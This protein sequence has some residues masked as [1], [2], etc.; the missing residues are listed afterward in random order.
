MKHR[1]IK[2]NY[3]TLEDLIRLT[4]VHGDLPLYCNTGTYTSN[5]FTQIAISAFDCA[6]EDLDTIT[7]S[8]EVARLWSTYIAPYRLNEFITYNEGDR[9]LDYSDDEEF[10]KWVRLF[11]NRIHT[12]Y[13]RYKT[14]IDYYDDKKDELLNKI[15]SSNTIRFND[16]PQNGGD[17]SADSYTSTYTKTDS[18]TD[19]NTLMARLDEIERLYKN[20]WLN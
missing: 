1:Y 13:D 3:Y 10:V 6:V 4:T 12:T 11:V 18:E 19:A 16:T 15:N 20:V 7:K 8:D 9:E 2:R 17:F 5:S 14:L